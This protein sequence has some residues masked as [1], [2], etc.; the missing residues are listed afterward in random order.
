MKTTLGAAGALLVAAFLGMAITS[1]AGDGASDASLAQALKQ[2]QLPLE[3]G[4]AASTR[5]GK[6]ISAKYELEDDD[7]DELQL[8]VYTL[9]EGDPIVDYET[10]DVTAGSPTF[11][12]VIV[13]YTTAKIVKV[14]SIKDGE[15][16][17]AARNQ[18]KAM[19]NAKRSL[20]AATALAVSAHAGYRAVSAMPDL[21]DGHAIVKVVLLGGNDWTTVYETLD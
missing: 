2:A 8:S 15:D 4:L 17:V 21:K 5:E 16:L 19:A 9:K 3:R 6:P 18:S 12:E 20:E 13:D 11:A 7:A 1:R 10:G 14:I